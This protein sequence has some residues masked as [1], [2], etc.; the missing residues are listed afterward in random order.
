MN[1]EWVTRGPL[2]YRRRGESTFEFSERE[3]V[4]RLGVKNVRQ[5]DGHVYGDLRAFVGATRILVR[6]KVNLTSDRS[7]PTLAKSLDLAHPIT[8]R[9]PASGEEEAGTDWRSVL[10][11]VCAVLADEM[12][13]RGEFTWLSPLEGTELPQPMLFRGF[14]PRGL[15]AGLVANGGTGKSLTAGLMALAV[16]T[17]TKIGPFEPLIPA[18]RVL[19]VDW[20]N[21][22]TIH[23]RRLQRIC[24]G[25][26]IPFPEARMGHFHVRGD[27][28]HSE[29]EIVERAYEIKAE[30]TIFDSIAFAAGGMGNLNAAEVATAA[31]N[32]MK[33]VPGTKIMIAHQSKAA[34]EGLTQ[35]RGPSNSV[36]FW[37]GCQSI[38][39]LNAGEPD[40]NGTVT[41]AIY[42]D[43]AN[44]GRKLRRP[45][46]VRVTFEDDENGGPITP[47]EHEVQGFES[48]GE[49][50][51]LATRILDYMTYAGGKVTAEDIAERLFGGDI[52]KDKTDSVKA[53]LRTLRQDGVVASEGDGRKGEGQKWWLA[54]E[55]QASDTLPCVR[56]GKPFVQYGEKGEPL[57][58]AH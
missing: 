7:L 19:Y 58:G 25:L 17:G 3:M 50:L 40:A 53:K 56:C 42:Q 46:G 22:A 29:G 36:F 41:F 38:Y 6:P 37:N 15:L 31:I 30:V 10:D 9:D 26:G 44:V 8:L 35:S 21:E 33:R 2:R 52:A 11:R 54:G 55:A 23:R 32:I 18:S 16:A 5:E 43:K 4:V 48:G 39:V 47:V 51:P 20:E 13:Q 24:K 28:R 45:L 14:I 34:A 57:C 1:D 27:L 49:G 12:D